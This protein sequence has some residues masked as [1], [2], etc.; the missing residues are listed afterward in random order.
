MMMSATCK[1][2]ISPIQLQK[3]VFLGQKTWFCDQKNAKNGNNFLKSP[4][5]WLEYTSRKLLCIKVTTDLHLTYSKNGGNLRLVL[6]M[7]NIACLSI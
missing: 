1:K 3:R 2:N 7:K 4:Q 5:W 6:N